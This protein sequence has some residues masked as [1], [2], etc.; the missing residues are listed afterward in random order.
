MPCSPS[1]VY[2]ALAATLVF[3]PN[4][5]DERACGF[6]ELAAFRATTFETT[7]FEAI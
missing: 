4:W 6:I 1:T 3:L 2:F 5:A 7:R